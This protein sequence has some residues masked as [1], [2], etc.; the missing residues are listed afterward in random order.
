[1]AGIDPLNRGAEHGHR[2]TAA[3]QTAPVSRPI[4][5][6]RQA[7]DHRPTGLSQGGPDRLRHGQAMGGGPAGTHYRNCLPRSQGR[8]E[9]AAAPPAQ[10]QGWPCQGQQCLRETA[11][12]GHQQ[13]AL[14]SQSQAG[15][16]QG[17]I[18]P[19]GAEGLQGFALTRGQLR[20]CAKLLG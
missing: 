5:S 17:I 15:Q 18:P 4:Y 19:I 11:I 9:P 20:P 14:P 6:L 10:A 16:G 7:A 3:G 8:P 1:M 13:G 12:A 2:P